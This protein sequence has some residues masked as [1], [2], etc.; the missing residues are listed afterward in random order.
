M[1]AIWP[2]SEACFFPCTCGML[3]AAS[4]L[5][6]CSAFEPEYSECPS[7]NGAIGGEQTFAKGQNLGQIASIRFNGIYGQCVQNAGYT[8]TNITVHILMER[9]MQQDQIAKL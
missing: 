1:G 4:T 8:D 6:G 7:I 2:L 5:V 3:G 9:D